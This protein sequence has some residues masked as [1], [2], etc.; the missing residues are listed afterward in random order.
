MQATRWFPNEHSVAGIK[1]I[2]IGKYDDAMRE[3]EAALAAN[4][5]NWESRLALAAVQ[6]SK[7]QFDAAKQNYTQ[8]NMDKKSNEPDPNCMAGIKRIEA[9]QKVGK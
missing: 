9:R 6:E 1:H 5:K 4:P 8:A 3:L 2:Q 7:G